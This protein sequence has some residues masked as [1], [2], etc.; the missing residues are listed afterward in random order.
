MDP[1]Y[2][3]AHRKIGDDKSKS[4]RKTTKS[5]RKKKG[6]SRENEQ[7]A[8]QVSGPATSGRHRARVAE[9][10]DERQERSGSGRSAQGDS[11]PLGNKCA[12]YTVGATHILD[13]CLGIS[14]FVYGALVS[15]SSVTATA[16]VC[17][18]F[19]VLGSVFG[20]LGYFSEVAERRGLHASALAGAVLCLIDIGAFVSIFVSWSKFIDF[21]NEHAEDLLLTSDAVST[22]D[23]LKVLFAVIFICLAGLEVHRAIA[24]WSLRE[25]MLQQGGRATR[26]MSPSS[27]SSWCPCLSWLGLSKK[28][29]TDDF[30]VFD[31]DASLESS[32]LWSKEGTQPA[33][34]DYLDFVPEHERG[35]ADYTSSVTLPEPKF[36]DRMDY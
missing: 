1:V 10:D 12:G 21:L 36:D 5:K 7:S 14:L 28:R 22:I 20:A 6:R 27:S 9:A 18:L 33:S 11:L 15:V 17:G 19:L 24:V 30:V 34:E 25:T 4:S 23:G 13:F 16:V 26:R 3:K 29:K 35:L 32:L 31:D 8:G 2:S